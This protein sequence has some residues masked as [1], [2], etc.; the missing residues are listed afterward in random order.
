M[1]R[2]CLVPLIVAL[3]GA[4]P[5]AAQDRRA[6]QIDA[7]FADLNRGDA[8]GCAVGVVHEG[9]LRFANG[10]GMAN[11]ERR[12]PITP[13][14]VFYLASVSKQFVAA[15]AAL[16][17]V[18]GRLS[19][20]DD[21]R[22]YVPELPDYGARITIR[23][24]LH[25]TSGLRDYLE[26]MGMAGMSLDEAW[27]PDTIL[28]LVARQAG[29]NFPPGARYLYSNTGYFL[30]PIIVQRVTGHPL[31]AWTATH[32]FGPLGMEHSHFHDDWRHAVARRALA[33]RP[34]DGGGYE[35]DFLPRF[36]QV[37]S[38]G[39]L[40]T[41][42]DLARWDGHFDSGTVGGPA[43][44]QLQLT[45]GVLADGDTLDYALGLELGEY[46]GLRTVE[47]GGSMMG[48]RTYSLRFPDERLT[49]ICLC[50]RADANPSARARQVAD[51]Y[52]QDRF[53]TALAAYAGT[54]RSEELGVTWHAEVAGASLTVRRPG[55]EATPLRSAGRDRFRHPRGQEIRFLR[56][57]GPVVGFELN[58]GRAQGIRF[59]RVGG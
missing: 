2:R 54:Y 10:Y 51:V 49:V 30:I 12:E 1:P 14:T 42:E 52:L 28:A 22:R 31:R 4:S 20:D 37:G 53:A 33:Y 29:L 7:V 35:V 27:T 24:L 21:V 8:P 50:N 17:A 40:S 13:S 41:V 44:R 36:D 9:V 3:V 57:G 43:L 25:H 45:R 18:Q 55:E 59:H 46:Q 16:L 56:E 6:A 26:L 5:L 34:A 38:G 15:S 48:F 23:H 11:L 32:L 39:L 58:G 19:L 47:H